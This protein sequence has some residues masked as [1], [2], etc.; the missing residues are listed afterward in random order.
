MCVRGGAAGAKREQCAR[1][2]GQASEWASEGCFVCAP[3]GRT[4]FEMGKST[5]ARHEKRLKMHGQSS[6]APVVLVE[7]PLVRVKQS[8]GSTNWKHAEF[9]D[10]AAAAAAEPVVGRRAPMQSD[11]SVCASACRLCALP[12][13]ARF[14]TCTIV[15]ARSCSKK[16][17]TRESMRLRSGLLPPLIPI[18]LR[19]EPAFRLTP[20]GPCETRSYKQRVKRSAQYL[21]LPK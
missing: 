4:M 12:S 2:I 17:R 7:C 3:G 16:I 10:R 18:A 14:I 5:G 20:V 21:P 8:G 11:V 19:D 6:Q 9:V 15:F 13:L 1:G